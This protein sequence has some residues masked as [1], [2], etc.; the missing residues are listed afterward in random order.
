MKKIIVSFL[1]SLVCFLGYAQ[2]PYP[3]PNPFG[4]KGTM[5]QAQG[6][7]KID[8]TAIM[9]V[10]ADTFAANRSKTS[11]YPGALIRVSDDYYYRSADTSKWLLL[12]TTT[13]NCA[14]TQLISGSITWSGSGLVYD[15]TDLDYY[16]LCS[17]YFA[18][19]TTLTL[20][21]ADPTYG[22]IDKFYADNTQNIGVI[23]GTPSANPQEP[24]VNP[25][26][27]IDL[28][29]VYIPAGSTVPAGTTQTVI[30][31]ENVEWSG[32]SNVPSVNFT[33][34]TNPYIGSVST[35]LPSAPN[36]SYVEWQSGGIDY[37]FS[38]AQY[39]KFW[40]RLNANFVNDPL[41]F[42]DVTFEYTDVT[43]SQ[44]LSVG[45]GDYNM[46]Y[47]L[48]NQWQLVSIP[49]TGITTF[50]T[51]F[52]SVHFV[53]NSAPTSF[54]LDYVYLLETSTVPPAPVGGTWLLN[55]NSAINDATQYI[56]TRDAKK[57]NIGTNGQIRAYI[58]TAGIKLLLGDTTA[59]V[60]LIDSNGKIWKKYQPTILADSPVIIYQ[61][62]YQ[63]RIK[64]DTTRR[65]AAV[66]TQYYADS[67]AN[68]GGGG[69]GT[70]FGYALSTTQPTDTSVGWINLNYN[71]LQCYPVQYH[72]NGAWTQ[73]DT[74]GG[75]F[76]DAIG[77]VFS[78]GY[79]YKIIATGQSNLGGSYIGEQANPLAPP[80]NGYYGD[81]IPARAVA[82]WNNN[83]NIWV[84]AKIRDTPFQYSSGANY[85]L[86][87]AKKINERTGRSV[88]I[89]T[90]P[91]GGTGLQCWAG[92]PGTPPQDSACYNEFKSR[93]QASGLLHPDV[94]IWAQSEAGITP[95]PYT[96]VYTDKWLEMVDSMI[97]R[98]HLMDTTTLK[99]L[100]ASG[101]TLTNGD[102]IQIANG[103]SAG[104]GA[105]RALAAT[106]DRTIKYIDAYS[107]QTQLT[108]GL[109]FLPKGHEELA[110][111]L[112]NSISEGQKNPSRDMMGYKQPSPYKWGSN[113][114]RIGLGGLVAINSNNKAYFGLGVDGNSSYYTAAEPNLSNQYSP[115]LQ[116]R[117]DINT[118]ALWHYNNSTKVQ[119][120]DTRVLT[121]NIVALQS[122][123][124][125]SGANPEFALNDISL[126]KKWKFQMA[127]ASNE[128]HFTYDGTRRFHFS[129]TGELGIGISGAELPDS[130]L[131]IKNGIWGE[132]GVR[133]SGLPT[134][135][136]YSKSLAITN[137]GTVYTKDTLAVSGVYALINAN[138]TGSAATLTT[139]RKINNVP[140]D[141]SADIGV[142]KKILA[143]QA[144]GSS[145]IA[146]NVDG[147]LSSGTSGQSLTSQ[148]CYISAVYLDKAQTVTGVKWVQITAGDYT[149]NNYNGVGL[150]SYSAG[151]LTLVASSTD[152]GN[153][154]K[155][156]TGTM[157]SKA[158][159]TPYSAAAGLYFVGFL[160][161]SSSQ[162]T[163]PS[164][165]I[166][167]A[168]STINT[169][170]DFTNSAKTSGLIT[171][172][173]A[174]P[175]SQAMSGITAAS[176][177]Y[178]TF[179][180]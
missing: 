150:Y 128:L 117:Q 125:Y 49:L 149:S 153:I 101:D 22:R 45:D 88:R 103:T 172:Q 116:F 4:S 46:D 129:K 138:T 112:Y 136:T 158:F 13:S 53:I 127:N 16:I 134:N 75:Q 130:M 160:Y 40:V 162:V 169:I 166:I 6:G 24:S 119:L 18:N 143:Y 104:E 7:W 51:E 9:P 37:L 124:V 115:G 95:S 76:Y 72:V 145:I 118:V 176:T 110:T 36:S 69:S 137:N 156:T 19:S 105:L 1:V 168:A 41:S 91:Q 167:N 85:L 63:D 140:F 98:D 122:L 121:S 142:D 56:G 144:L 141:G 146:S 14:G 31:N 58:D 35:Y 174:L 80:Y 67:V 62:G 99:I 43:V 93:V 8:S 96:D 5:T 177:E 21:T 120:E 32:T 100:M 50:G 34:G 15:A 73:V 92:V 178:K 57:L 27:Q 154:W 102:V 89:V 135:Q 165:G 106:N 47:S 179:L 113:E 159:S 23:T 66:A 39:L 173:T 64:L 147:D 83:Q 65:G 48:I 107:Y 3:S 71:I 33:Y 44:T 171:G 157:S 68:A 17:R 133:F 139:A 87:A 2:T 131:R 170:T 74:I 70:P 94:F 78:R 20:A 11:L 111:R 28:G 79:P 84:V 152:D 81:T 164:L 52:N 30:Y 114:Q 38:D 55:G 163:A 151:T 82:A 29:F 123:E 25:L 12:A 97:A 180:Y 54:Q 61:N 148:R 90:Y 26:T 132:R 161:C 10:Y 86:L 77:G 59:N 175:A 126:N 108:D 60:M 42:L 155:A 109:H